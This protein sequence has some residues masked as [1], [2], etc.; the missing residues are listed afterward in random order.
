[1]TCGFGEYGALYPV[2]QLL[3]TGPFG[4]PSRTLRLALPPL[5]EYVQR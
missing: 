3:T 4:P 5:Q 1:M 2:L